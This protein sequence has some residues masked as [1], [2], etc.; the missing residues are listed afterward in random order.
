[1]KT[2]VAVAGLILVVLLVI[3]SG[4]VAAETNLSA[5]SSFKISATIITEAIEVKP[6]DIEFGYISDL[7]TDHS[8][9]PAVFEVT[10]TD[11]EYKVDLQDRVELKNSEGD[12]LEVS[13]EAPEQ[14]EISDGEDSFEVNATLNSPSEDISDGNYTGTSTITVQYAN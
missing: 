8:A 14:G 4:I 11:V 6:D 13:L 2:K 9:E 3:N 1:M 10:G 5:E 7:E 12:S